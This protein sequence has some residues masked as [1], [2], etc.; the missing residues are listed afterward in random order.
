M[1]LFVSFEYIL[2]K[3]MHV[4]MRISNKFVIE[5]NKFKLCPIMFRKTYSL[6]VNYL[7]EG[8][9]ITNIPPFKGHDS[10]STTHP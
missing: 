3:K 7:C 5:H 1:L 9:E 6:M 4:K 8:S 2:M 10:S